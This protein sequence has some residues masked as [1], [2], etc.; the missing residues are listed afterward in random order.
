MKFAPADIVLSPVT[1]R[2]F[3]NQNYVLFGNGQ[4]VATPSPILT[5]IRLDLKTFFQS[6]FILGQPNSQAPNAQALSNLANGLLYNSSGNLTTVLPGNFAPNT[7]KYILQQPDLALPNSQAL[8]D[9]DGGIL[10]SAPSTGMINIAIA[11]SDYCTPTTVSV[12]IAAA[13]TSAIAAAAVAS[14]AYFTAQMLPFTLTP[15]AEIS[16]SIAAAAALGT[17]AQLTANNANTRIDGLT[18]TLSGD[19]TGS[20]NISGS[21]AT[22]FAPNP[23]FTGN[24][25]TIPAG[26][27]AASP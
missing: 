18:V 9:L 4:G 10:K 8:S 22:T 5:D 11:D 19:I 17:A 14:T 12:A 3:C 27:T 26:N 2:I 1:G 13:E 20:H 7:S 25:V 21:V 15:G 6:D 16:I 24:A 23:V